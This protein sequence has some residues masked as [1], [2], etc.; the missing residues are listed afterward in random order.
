MARIKGV[1]IPDNKSLF[2][3]GDDYGLPIGNLSSQMFANF[4]LHELD[5]WLDG[6]FIYGR[7]VDDFYL[8]GK[9][10]DIL[11]AVPA[12]RFL[13]GKLNI[14]L[15]PKKWYLQHWTK[16][17]KFLGAVSK[18]GRLYVGNRTVHNAFRVV[19]EINAITDKEKE[20]EVVSQRLNSYLGYLGQFMTYAIRRR[21]VAKISYDWYHY[22]YI[23][24]QAKKVVLRKRFRNNVIVKNKVT[25]ERTNQY[26]YC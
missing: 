24:N 2:R 17:C 15:H 3:N 11:A 10:E 23:T 16:G 5:K 9:K 13:L 12:I 20:A 26:A 1:D 19:D 25:A 22:F 14:T 21:L 4:Y 8:I 18:N 6:M 7:Y